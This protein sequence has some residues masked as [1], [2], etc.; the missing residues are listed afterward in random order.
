MSDPSDTIQLNKPTQL[1]KENKWL[2]EKQSL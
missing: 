2:E 1:T